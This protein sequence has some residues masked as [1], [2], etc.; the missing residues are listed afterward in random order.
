V[1]ELLR[2]LVGLRNRPDQRYGYGA[3]DGQAVPDLF[4]EIMPVPDGVREVVITSDGYPTPAPTL[5]ESERLL[6]ERLA[7]DPLML[8]PP[9]TKGKRPAA[10]SFDDRAYL[11]VAL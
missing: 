4:V 7:R 10:N 3:L 9:E 1:Q 2:A 8:D 6:A 5:A 11:R